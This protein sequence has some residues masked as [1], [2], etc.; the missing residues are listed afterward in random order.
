MPLCT[1][2]LL[3]LHHNTPKPLPNFLSALESSDISP[4]IV[5]HVIRW[6]ILPS[7]ISTEHL[8][9]RNISWDIL[10]V[11]PNNPTLPPNL[12]KFI[13]YHWHITAG[14][15]SRLLQDFPTKNHALLHPPESSNP[16]TTKATAATRKTTASAQNL[17]L[18]AE[19]DSW[20]EQRLKHGSSDATTAVSMLNLLSFHPGQKASYLEYGAAFSS[21]IG[22]AHGGNAKIVGSV[23]STNDVAAPPQ[24]SLDVVAAAR[25]GADGS[26]GSSG[27]SGA[28][29][30][31]AL[32][33][34]P[35]IAH[36]RD[37]LVSDEYQRVNQ[38][39]RVPSL[40]D[41]AILMTSEVGIEEMMGRGGAAK[42]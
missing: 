40:S 20:I 11:L 9:A 2:H 12:T 42:L 29:D 39:F 34:Y 30:E 23:V 27:S 3:A 36:F 4:L 32:A 8:L 5:S 24:S 14:V 28:W 33:H 35:S 25:L 10:L 38:R 31:I 13:A 19:L 16:P 37:M 15:P 17:E 41:T 26:V 1:L 21:S 22:S 6:I 18:S 7:K